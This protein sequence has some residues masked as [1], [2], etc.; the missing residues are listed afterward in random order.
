MCF[1]VVEL[2]AG[3]RMVPAGRSVRKACV[4]SLSPSSVLLCCA[5]AGWHMELRQHARQPCSS[6]Q[7]SPVFFLRVHPDSIG[8]TKCYP[9]VSG[10][11]RIKIFLLQRYLLCYLLCLG[12]ECFSSEVCVYWF[13]LYFCLFISGSK[14]HSKFL[15]AIKVTM[16]KVNIC[17]H[18]LP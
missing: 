13:L 17:L 3:R 14:Y 6:E 4:P 1:Q 18:N 8:R 10:N 2:R 15:L 7:C 12:M 16:E 9:L 11:C 5:T